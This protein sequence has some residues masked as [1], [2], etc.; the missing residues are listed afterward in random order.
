MDE[1]GREQ[2]RALLH[3]SPRTFG[4]PTGVWTLGLV[5]EVSFAE[6]IT[7]DRMWL[8][9]V[10]GRPVSAITAAYLDW[11]CRKLQAAGK[12]ELKGRLTLH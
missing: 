10:D 11:C 5:A 12:E 7:A 9:F 6:G 2:L 1:V 4:K 3:R 8:R